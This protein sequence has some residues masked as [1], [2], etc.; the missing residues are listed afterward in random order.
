MKI[1]ILGSGGVGVALG[2]KLAALGHEVKMGSREAN[3]PKA[4]DWAKAAGAKASSGTFADAA[5]FGELV[6]N[7]TLGQAALAALTAAG[8]PALKG[9][10]LVDVS[11]PLDFSKGFPPSLTVCNTDSLAE[12]IQR[13]FPETKVV[14]ALNT[15]PNHL[16]VDPA[17]L[18]G[19]DHD[20]LMCGNDGDAKA[21]VAE[22]LGGFG[23]KREHIID[24]GDLT[25]ARGTEAWMLLWTRLYGA[26][27]TGDFQLKIVR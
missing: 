17:K 20:L 1:G 8:A 26:F 24:V 16:M 22:L 25:A 12:Q 7:C 5:Q 27:K 13:A 18:K 9:K 23:W 10:V 2:T 19:G 4:R 21:K 11:N 3:N 15:M 6:F 14:K